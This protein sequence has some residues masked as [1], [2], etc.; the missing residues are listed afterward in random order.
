M[1]SGPQDSKICLSG[2]EFTR[3]NLNEGFRNGLIHIIKYSP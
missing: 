1:E 2:I 3:N